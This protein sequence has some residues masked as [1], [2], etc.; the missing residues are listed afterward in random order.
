MGNRK[1]KK[2]NREGWRGGGKEGNDDDVIIDRINVAR[3]VGETRSAAVYMKCDRHDG[4]TEKGAH[5]VYNN[6]VVDGGRGRE[7]GHA[8]AANGNIIFL[9]GS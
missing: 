4:T 1:E 6:N 7:N 2:E 5:H 9:A 8:A 3:T